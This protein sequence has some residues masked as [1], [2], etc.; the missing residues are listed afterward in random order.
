VDIKGKI[1]DMNSKSNSL[2]FTDFLAS[3]ELSEKALQ[4]SIKEKYIKG[5]ASSYH[6]LGIAYYFNRDNDN[7]YKFYKKA[8]EI[9]IGSEFLEQQAA[10]LHNMGLIDCDRS[11]FVKAINN[12]KKAL[13]LRKNAGNENL[14]ALSLDYIGVNHQAMNDF[15]NSLRYYLEAYKLKQKQKKPAPVDILRSYS[16]IGQV[17]LNQLKNDTAIVY[18]RKALQIA[19]ENNHEEWIAHLCSLLGDCNNNLGKYSEALK[20][21]QKSSNIF[22]KQKNS[23]GFSA[24]LNAMAICYDS[25]NN[26]EKSLEYHKK[27]L[28][29]SRKLNL[30]Q[31]IVISLRSIGSLHVKLKNY[32]LAE[33]SY[34]KGLGIA[35]E[36]NDKVLISSFYNLK[37][38]MYAS[39]SRFEEAYNLQEK[40]F[41]I[42]EEINESQENEAIT[43]LKIEFDLEQKER[44]AEIHKLKNITLVEAN[45]KLAKSEKNLKNLTQTLEN[46]V[47]E[48]LKK[49]EHQQQQ[50]IQKSKL[51]SIGKLAAGIV[52]EINQPLGG[53][54]MGLDNIYFAY[55]EGR[56]TDN[57]FDEKLKH[58]DGYFERINQI[59]DHI[60]IFSRDQKSILFEDIDINQT[61]KDA[62]SL[63]HTQYSN[64][65]VELIIEQDEEVPCV[66]GN[67]FKLEQVVL[68]LLTNAKDAVEERKKS[69]PSLQKK[70]SIKTYGKED[71]V[72]MEIED[73]GSGISE[74][75]LK[76]IFDPFFTT[77]DPSKGTGLGLSI[78]YGIIKEMNGE[79]SVKSKFGEF[80]RMK[81]NFRN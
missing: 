64:H 69:D 62:L 30:K 46:R 5:E 31:R 66:R 74:E 24:S 3:K 55:S 8:Y 81:V 70:I 16:N 54:S 11:E 50:L 51:E 28:A 1:N 48:E 29:I 76:N 32:S 39:Q 75:H 19:E 25:L 77:K 2:A 10:A 72:I 60:R 34:D 37:S 79:I 68:N 4:L 73:N 12:H 47:Q 38:S 52:H 18:F 22:E 14:I 44:E 80:T 13:D 56:L 61:I 71:D 41:K 49:R 23:R 15:E 78:I 57:Y 63:L 40:F 42:N 17:Y 26:P 27:A 67:R 21:L 65:N 58:I 53:I 9:L 35:L 6:N 33:S 43:R 7:S 59:I 36:I 20:L 45:T